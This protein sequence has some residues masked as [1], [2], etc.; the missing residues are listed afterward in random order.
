[1]KL[2]SR[3][4]LLRFFLAFLLV[5]ILASC[6]QAGGSLL[7]NQAKPTAPP[8]PKAGKTSMTGRLVGKKDG[9]PLLH[10][11][12]RLARVYRQGDQG[13]YV[14]DQARAP[15]N[16][17]DDKGYFVIQDFDVYEY[18]IIIGEPNDNHYWIM[19]DSTT[20][21]I[22]YKPEQDKV[23]DVGTLTVDFVP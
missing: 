19:Q 10:V 7:P 3:S 15:G 13:A 11:A 20:K 8:A 22:G 9:A 16:Y 14:L 21:P 18:F 2:P 1:M 5:G 23:L 4:P 6:A 17:T 12:V